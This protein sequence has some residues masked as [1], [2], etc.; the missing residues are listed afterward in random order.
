MYALQ[1][2]LFNV[3]AMTDDTGA[4]KQRYA[5]QPYGESEELNPDFTSY[6]GT[7]YEW[8]YRFTG[9]ELDLET[10]LQLNRETGI[11]ASARLGRWIVE[12]SDSISRRDE[13]IMGMWAGCQRGKSNRSVTVLKVAPIL[14]TWQGII[15][16]AELTI[17]HSTRIWLCY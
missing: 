8:E 6:T 17:C 10:G 1:D 4:V 5:Y 9:R 13:S 15:T 3:V 14:I 16:V 7:N 11:Y 12:G 2:A